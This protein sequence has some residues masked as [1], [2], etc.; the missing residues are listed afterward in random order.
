VADRLVF[1]KLRARFGGN[2]RFFICGGAPLS[3]EIAE[4]FHACGILILEGYGLTETS[5]A[6]FVN[7]VDAY[8]FGSVGQAIPG[9]EL[10]IA[11]S[12]GEILIK[13]RGVMRGYYNMPEASAEVLHDGWMHTGDIGEVDA[14]GFLKITDRKKDLI[15]TSGGKYVAPQKLEGKLKTLSPY[16]SQVLVHGNTRNFCSALITLNEDEIRKWAGDNGLGSAS[17]ADIAADDRTKSMISKFV[18]E[19]NSS[20]ASYE[21]IKKFSLLPADFAQET[22]EL[23]P[24]LKV[25][26]KVVE[27]KYKSMLDDFYAGAVQNI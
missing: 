18:T 21:T 9:V 10:K 8:K 24:T 6:S 11:E 7:T 19:L 15:K 14:K 1:S 2:I 3:R 5:A 27:A 4:F 26:R 16:I 25:K 13:S 12:D 20:L 17:Y 23:T 22:G